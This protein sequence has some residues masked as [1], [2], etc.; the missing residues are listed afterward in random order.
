VLAVKD[1]LIDDMRRLGVVAVELGFESAASE[2]LRENRKTNR[3]ADVVETAICKLNAAGLR[4]ILNVLSG[5]PEETPEA[6]AETL[7]FIRRA[8]QEVWLYNLYNFVPYPL[9]SQF[10]RIRDRIVDW[11]FRNWREDGPP[12]FEPWR[13]ARAESYEFL[14]EK[15][16]A[17]HAAIRRQLPN[18]EPD[19][20]LTRR[21]QVAEVSP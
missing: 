15:V 7:E 13:V 2:L 21:A 11:E 19:G 17:A 20:S 18:D 9:T 10:H 6:H 8:G 5:L 12:V 16:T 4:V 14:L 1:N 3:S